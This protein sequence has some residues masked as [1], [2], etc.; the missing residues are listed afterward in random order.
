MV[1]EMASRDTRFDLDCRRCVRLSALPINGT[2]INGA[3]SNLHGSSGISRGTPTSGV[4]AET[5]RRLQWG[6][7]WFSAVG[8]V[9]L[10]VAPVL[11]YLTGA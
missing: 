11:Q 2:N 10:V 1:H 9:G 5:T 7:V 8:V 6:I 3:V 4:K